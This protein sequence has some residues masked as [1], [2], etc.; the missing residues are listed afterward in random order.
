[1]L[2]Q[3]V[4]AAARRWFAGA[5]AVALLACSVAASAAMPREDTTAGSA[6]GLSSIPSRGAELEAGAAQGVQRTLLSSH[7]N[8][9]GNGKAAGA[10]Q[11][12]THQPHTRAAPESKKPPAGDFI[13]EFK[14]RNFPYVAAERP[15]L[16]V[17]SKLA[18]QLNFDYGDAEVVDMEYHV[19]A[20]IDVDDVGQTMQLSSYLKSTWNDWRVSYS[21]PGMDDFYFVLDSSRA[22]SPAKPYRLPPTPANLDPMALWRPRLDDS[23][24]QLDSDDVQV[25]EYHLY[26]DGTVECNEHYIATYSVRMDLKAYPFDK[27]YLV[28]T[29]RSMAYGAD[30]MQLNATGWGFVLPPHDDIWKY[31]ETGMLICD[32]Q[33]HGSNPDTMHAML[34]YFRVDRNPNYATQNQ[35]VPVLLI[36]IMSAAA[37]YQEL[38]AYNDRMTIMITSLLAMMALEQFIIQ[39]LPQTSVNTW[40]HYALF[41][42]YGLMG[43]GVLHIIIVS[44][45]LR[46]DMKRA[47]EL[48]G[49]DHV[50]IGHIRS[51]Y[52]NSS[53]TKQDCL[54]GCG[55]APAASVD[56]GGHGMVG[57][58]PPKAW[59]RFM[60]LFRA[61]EAETP[62]QRADMEAQKPQ[63]QFHDAV[64]GDVDDPHF[65]P[66]AVMEAAARKHGASGPPA[67]A[68]AHEDFKPAMPR[69]ALCLIYMDVAMRV[70]HL[71]I[72][73]L[74]L[75]I[76]YGVVNVEPPKP[77]CD[78][79]SNFF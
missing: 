78:T 54:S 37:Y 68:G 63:P 7:P 32:H 69:F 17:P 38:D 34:F 26:P 27:H 46:K 6:W 56:A 45:G 30:E 52:L 43:Y 57:S 39:A 13:G 42:A 29:R 22:E 11:T 47:M 73:G 79:M 5:A 28:A 59:P 70:L 77:T 50:S 15:G 41:T 36:V 1:M 55:G 58:T 4:R 9:R 66:S 12:S 74:V 35:L 53:E 8:H 44:Y 51:Y 18:S 2:P 62:S 76:R 14:F 3:P 31:K 24:N 40:M 49:S 20:V 16:N 48:H 71:G 33:E 61:G 19:L 65:T 10:N 60:M 67:D 21:D 64:S 23:I 75:I 25:E 72:F